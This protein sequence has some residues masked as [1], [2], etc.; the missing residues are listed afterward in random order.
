MS[1]E[2]L[3]AHYQQA[4]QD[5]DAARYLWEALADYQGLQ[6]IVVAYKASA[7]ALMARHAWNPY[8]KYGYVREALR[9]FGQAIRLE[10]Q[11]LEIRFLRF[12]VLHYMPGFLY[13]SE[14]LEEDKAVMKDQ[15]AHYRDAGLSHA[16]ARTFLEFY[17]E[18]GRFSQDELNTLT[19]A[20]PAEPDQ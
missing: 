10:P 7:R 4:V 16:Q 11:Q 2:S 8:H 14:D 17:Q 15:F 3:R 1:P 5:A 18:S 9:L 13:E 12:A 6:G 20:L 19:A